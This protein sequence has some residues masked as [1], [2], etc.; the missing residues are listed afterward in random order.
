MTQDESSRPGATSTASAATAR[1]QTWYFNDEPF[2]PQGTGVVFEK[3]RVVQ[4]FTVWQ[5][6]VGDA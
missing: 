1:R 3:G 2:M 5:P 4:A 6:T